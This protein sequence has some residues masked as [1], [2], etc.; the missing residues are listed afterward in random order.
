MKTLNKRLFPPG[1]EPGTFRV[2]GGCD[3]HYTTETPGRTPTVRA[4]PGESEN[5]HVVIGERTSPASRGGVPLACLS[6]AV[7]QVVERS[8]SM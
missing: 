2:L 3:N 5:S 8:L 7:A 4:A 6:G 1:I